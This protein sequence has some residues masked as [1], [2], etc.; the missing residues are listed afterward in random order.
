MVAA[1]AAVA[2]GQYAHGK[3]DQ[4]HQR[5]GGEDEFERGRQVLRDVHSHRAVAV[6]RIA[7]VAAG[8]LARVCPILER[9]WLIEA[10]LA[11]QGLHL[12]LGCVGTERDACG[13]PG[14]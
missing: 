14:E 12:R 3:A 11:P 10:A 7:E 13:I 2:R 1:T 4:R 5:A 8:K 6:E 9:N